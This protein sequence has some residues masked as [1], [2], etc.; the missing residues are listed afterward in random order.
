MQQQ[1]RHTV[2][3]I[4]LLQERN[5]HIFFQLLQARDED[6]LKALDIQPP[7]VG[8]FFFFAR[9]AGSRVRGGGDR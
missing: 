1:K 7:E 9:R 4:F 8:A 2:M 5:Y 6:D 3:N